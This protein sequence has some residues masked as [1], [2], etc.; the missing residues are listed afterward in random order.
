MSIPQFPKACSFYAGFIWRRRDRLEACIEQSETLWGPVLERSGDFHFGETV[1]YE[2][3]MGPGLMRTYCIYERPLGDSSELV[4]R[5]L[6]AACMERASEE[7]GRRT[8]NLDPGYLNGHQVVVATFKDYAHRIH[9]GRG[10][11]AHLEY[12]YKNGEP[13]LL[14]WT[15]PDF[16][17]D[18]HLALFRAW[19]KLSKS[20]L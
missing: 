2:P 17:R 14:P 19:R 6:Q 18:D 15:Y 10:I 20:R 9:L 4:Q 16:R 3:E 12:M 13:V 7:H 1:Y 11:Y 8:V 5:K